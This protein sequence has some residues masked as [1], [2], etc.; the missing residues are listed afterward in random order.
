M[1]EL[2]NGEEVDLSQLYR[3]SAAPKDPDPSEALFAQLT[4]AIKPTTPS[5]S[6][7]VRPPTPNAAVASRT[8]GAPAG[9]TA[10][11]PAASGGAGP[12]AD[13]TALLARLKPLGITDLTSLRSKSDVELRKLSQDTVTYELR[14][15]SLSKYFR[16]NP[17]GSWDFTTGPDGQPTGLDASGK[18]MAAGTKPAGTT[19]A[20]ATAPAPKPTP[21]KATVPAKK[22]AVAKK[23]PVVKKTTVK[24]PPAKKKTT[25]K[26]APRKAP[27]VKR[28][29][30]RKT[31]SKSRRTAL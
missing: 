8:G 7:T 4:G 28:P 24:R 29:P 31:I 19:P 12:S 6:T 5:V 25:T 20:K 9:G 13:S 17:D 15:Q 21:A 1:P 10:P 26:P 2:F 18:K 23:K 14:Q 30:A 3:D 27:A 11:A 22:K 16:Q